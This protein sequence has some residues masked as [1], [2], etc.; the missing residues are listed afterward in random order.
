MAK[1]T[2][3]LPALKEGKTIE[4]KGRKVRLS[5]EYYFVYADEYEEN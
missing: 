2:E 1:I 4:Y 5:E 3:L